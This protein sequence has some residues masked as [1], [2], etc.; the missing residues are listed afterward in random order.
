MGSYGTGVYYPMFNNKDGE[1]SSS[2]TLEETRR[3]TNICNRFKISAN[4]KQAQ[5]LHVC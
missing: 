3:A 2:V 5:E 4:T 1:E